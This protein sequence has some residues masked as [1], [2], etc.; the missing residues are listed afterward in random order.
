[1]SR[2]DLLRIEESIENN[3]TDKLYRLE[4]EMDVKY[5]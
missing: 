5:S 1:M 3:N 2:Q 4:K